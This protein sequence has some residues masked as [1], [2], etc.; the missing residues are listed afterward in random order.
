[1][2]AFKGVFDEHG[3]VKSARLCWPEALL[4]QL[5]DWYGSKAVANANEIESGSTRG[6]SKPEPELEP[7][8]GWE[9]EPEKT[10]DRPVPRAASQK[11]LLGHI[12]NTVGK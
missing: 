7:N 9:P 1:M 8:V 6:G 12:A 5:G 11:M 3:D 4:A 10:E 2:H